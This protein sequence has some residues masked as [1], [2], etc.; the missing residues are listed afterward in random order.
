MHMNYYYYYYYGSISVQYKQQHK[1]Q[2]HAQ[3]GAICAHCACMLPRPGWQIDCCTWH[4][5]INY[6]GRTSATSLRIHATTSSNHCRR[7][8]RRRNGW[9][10]HLINVCV[11]NSAHTRASTLACVAVRQHGYAVQWCQWR[12]TAAA[13]SG[14][15]GLLLRGPQPIV[16]ASVCVC[17]GFPAGGCDLSQPAVCLARG[18]RARVRILRLTPAKTRT[19]EHTQWEDNI[20]FVANGC[21][22]HIAC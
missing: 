2:H 8:R 22:Y 21:A 7:R 11:C 14:R 17:S 12:C 16:C 9:W 5:S 4:S 19:H 18:F 15:T 6:L 10:I 1:R 3:L 13:A 20:D